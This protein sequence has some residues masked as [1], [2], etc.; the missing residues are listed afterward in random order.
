MAA[1]ETR[2][3]LSLSSDRYR[4]K[5]NSEIAKYTV[6]ALFVFFR[7]SRNMKNETKTRKKLLR[8]TNPDSKILCERTLPTRSSELAIA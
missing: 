6:Y 3:A 1:V 2:H 4:L 8:P 7:W 5:K